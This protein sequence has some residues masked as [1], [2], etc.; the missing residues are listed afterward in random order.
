M[1]ACFLWII[2]YKFCEI[3]FQSKKKKAAT[4]KT[5][6]L[7]SDEDSF[8]GDSPVAVAPRARSRRQNN[9]PTKYRYSDEND[10]SD[11]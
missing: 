8:E 4:K 6:W 5:P 7:N 3:W 1:R 2:V 10:D 9:K 11:F